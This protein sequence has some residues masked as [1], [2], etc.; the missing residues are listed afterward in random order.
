MLTPVFDQTLKRNPQIWEHAPA[1][2]ARTDVAAIRELH[3]KMHDGRPSSCPIG[4]V[5]IFA[6]RDK[7]RRVLGML[8]HN[9]PRCVVS[10][11]WA[12]FDEWGLDTTVTATTIDYFTGSRTEQRVGTHRFRATTRPHQFA[13]EVSRMVRLGLG[14]TL[15]NQAQRLDKELSPR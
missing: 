9:I 14:L 3:R 12:M 11:N 2:L 13:R 1:R 10:A 4:T 8:G 6:T 7:G 15:W 5:S